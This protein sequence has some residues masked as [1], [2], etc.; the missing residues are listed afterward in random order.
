MIDITPTTTKLLK[1]R[2]IEIILA[3][4]EKH[5]AQF[6][7]AE[8]D[9]ILASHNEHTFADTVGYPQDSRGHNVNDRNY[10]DDKNA[11]ARVVEMAANLEPSILVTTSRTAS[12]TPIITEPGIVVSGNNRTMSLKLAASDHP[13]QYLEYKKFLAE[14]I[15]SFGFEQLIGT[16]LLLGS[17]IFVD[18]SSFHDS[19]SITFEK[20]ILVRIDYDFPDY[21]TFELA[22]YNKETKKAERPVDKA[23]KLS[24]ILSDNQGLRDS[25]ANI[26]GEFETLSDFYASRSEQKH[27]M[28]ILVEA[29]LIT[30]QEKPA[31]YSPESGFNPTGKDLVEL[32]LSSLV[33]QKETLQATEMEG[34]R[35]FRAT[36]VTSLPVLVKNDSLKHGNLVPAIN[37]AIE[38]AVKI[39]TSKL[40]FMDYMAQLDMFAAPPTRK[41]AILYC[42][43]ESGR[44]TFKKAIELYNQ[45]VLENEGTSLFE[46]I[47]LTPDEIFE[48]RIAY[49]IDKKDLEVVEKYLNKELPLVKESSKIDNNNPFPN[50]KIP[51]TV[52]H[53]T[54]KEFEKFDHGTKGSNT[55]GRNTF[56]GFFFSEKVQHTALFGERV[57]A[58]KINVMKPLDIRLNSIFKIEEQASD[59]YYILQG[60]RLSNKE[61]LERL[62]DEIGLG[63]IDDVR[64]A[65]N[66]QESHD[67]MVELGYDCIIS[68][69]GDGEVEYIVFEPEQ[70]HILAQDL[71]TVA[72]NTN[73]LI[74][75]NWYATY[76]EKILGEPYET[77]GRF[78]KVTKYRG[79][80]SSLDKIYTGI[81]LETSIRK[82]EQK[83]ASNIAAVVVEEREPEFPEKTVGEVTYFEE[84]PSDIKGQIE[85]MAMMSVKPEEV[86]EIA[87]QPEF[88]E[89]AEQHPTGIAE[90]AVIEQPLL[91]VEVELPVPAKPL[92]IDLVSLHPSELVTGSDY[93]TMADGEFGPAGTKV[94]LMGKGDGQGNELLIRK[95]MPDGKH[96]KG[97]A[98]IGLIGQKPQGYKPVTT[99]EQIIAQAKTE[100]ARKSVARIKAKQD[101][102]TFSMPVVEMQSFEEIYRLYNPEISQEELKVFVFYKEGIGQRLSDKWTRL[103]FGS[104]PMP[105]AT[106]VEW[107]ENGLLCYHQG[108]MLPSFL[109]YAENVWQR[110]LDLEQDRAIII[111]RYGQQVF[112][113]QSQKLEKLFLETVYKK[114]LLLNDSDEVQ[115]LR[116]TPISQFAKDFK[117]KSLADEKPFYIRMRGGE[118]ALLDTVIDPGYSEKRMYQGFDEMNLTEAFML[119]MAFNKNKLEYKRN[120]TY[121]DI[122][123]AYILDKSRPRNNSKM[124]D[125]EW[126]AQWSR[127]KENAQVEGDRLF[128]YFLANEITLNDKVRIETEWNIKFNAYVPIDYDKVPVAFSVAK[129]YRNEFVEVRPEK[130]EAVAIAILQGSQI[131]AFDVGFGKTWTLIMIFKALLEAGYCTR[132]FL[133]TPNQ[134]Y[135]QF[136]SEFKGLMP[137]V[138]VIDLYNLGKDYM[139]ELRGKDGKVSMLP[140]G[141]MALATY[142]GLERV[143]FNENT[144][145]YLLGQMYEILENVKPDKQMLPKQREQFQQKLET[146]LGTGLRNTIVNIEDLGIDFLSIDEAHNMKKIFT[147]VK[148]EGSLNFDQKGKI[149]LSREHTPY[150]IDSG[151][152]SMIGL[153]A[154][155][156]SQYIQ[157]NNNGRNVVLLTATPFTNSPLE[158][159]SMLALVAYQ[160][161]S[162]TS[163]QNLTVFFD[164]FIEISY[165]LVI[166]ATLQPVRKQVV[167]GFSNLPALQQIIFRYINFKNGDTK[168]KFGNPAVKVVRPN[169]WRLP[170][171]YKSV[172]GVTELLPENERISTIIPMTAT[173]ASLMSDIRLYV[174]GGI[175]YDELCRV[176]GKPKHSIEDQEE[177]QGEELEEISEQSLNDKEKRSVRMLRGISMARKLAL[178]PYL[179]E[180]SG[181]PE[182]PSPSQFVNESPKI[183]YAL[184]SIKQIKEFCKKE[185]VIM[186][187]QVIYMDLGKAFFPLIKRYLVEEVGF[188]SHEVAIV[189][190]GMPKTGKNSKEAIK[191]LFN[192]QIYNEASRAFE[193]VEDDERV[194]IVLGTSTIVEGMNLQRYSTHL[195]NLTVDWNPTDDQQLEG[196]IWRQ[197]NTYLNVAIILLLVE[198]SM[199]IFIFQ[200]LEEKSKRIN[201]IWDRDGQSSVFKFEEFNPEEAKY[202]M[203]SDPN[204]LAKLEV[205][206]T[207]ARLQDELAALT[208]EQRRIVE[209]RKN[210]TT[211]EDAKEMLVEEAAKHRKLYGNESVERLIKLILDVE[212]TQM[213][214]AELEK[215]VEERLPLQQ[216]YKYDS[217][218]RFYGYKRPS[219]LDTVNWANRQSKRDQ[220]NYLMPRNLQFKDLEKYQN[221]LALRSDGI[222]EEI[223][224]ITSEESLKVRA[225]AIAERRA[226]Q[227]IETKSVKARVAE[228]AKLNWIALERVVNVQSSNSEPKVESQKL[229]CPPKDASGKLRIDAEALSQLNVCIEALPQTK[230]MYLVEGTEDYTPSREKLHH[231]IIEDL[232]EGHQCVKREK[233]LAILTGG[234]PGAGKSTYLKRHAAWLTS[235]KVF[236]IDADEVRSMLPE[237]EGW[238][239]NATHLETKDI[240]NQLL[241]SIGK[242]CN[243]DL[244]YD[245]TMN[246]AKNY[247]PLIEK[248]QKLGYKVFVIYFQVPLDVSLER[249]LKR[250]QDTGRYVPTFVIHEAYQ[251]GIKTFE[252]IKQIVDGYMLIDGVSGVTIERGGEQMREDRNYTLP[253]NANDKPESEELEEIRGILK[254]YKE[255][256][257]EEHDEEIAGIAKIYEEMLEEVA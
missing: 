28:D 237:Y 46:N 151:M 70:I 164:Q 68:S 120:I 174:E 190:S 116:L 211:V 1:G 253:E 99:P 141:S 14:E 194:K 13:E 246:K 82:A 122:V 61:A 104:D 206:D 38:I 69:L 107:V 202:E 130:R 62:N 24:H 89:Q 166:T 147:R 78:G 168:D 131:V 257:E 209:I 115:A 181:L 112:D 52:Y 76:P 6:A 210:H 95:F 74:N 63:E 205:E 19:H 35:K 185:G 252:T 96:I 204:V 214:S 256:L 59:I 184:L 31:Y 32:L 177:I 139:D 243:F 36:I 16:N 220:D 34:V 187:G 158:V 117:V 175:E 135:R 54:N 127:T 22:K 132:G 25:V 239:A 124:S 125:S 222:K 23:I 226:E 51:Q 223:S 109:Y 195:Y 171:K 145:S 118:K 224:A 159:Y 242:P 229:E 163:I 128:A 150:Q 203:I 113:S 71:K 207:I 189:T 111:E 49:A 244:V 191:N 179:F 87:A 240:V 221:Q 241:D 212:F 238:N 48:K 129:N 180:C 247:I 43:L 186:P 119:W 91:S 40:S 218:L 12:G 41:A 97:V 58:A 121:L 44:N 255:M 105:V 42:L 155:M 45:S 136:M 134:V 167:T 183:Q 178:S 64:D 165:Q 39:H 248:L 110:K 30:E 188:K 232:M 152:P 225:Q 79:S 138:P 254:L 65:F 77:T 196:R 37:S 161:L 101:I 140:E 102:E 108:K 50:S 157:H 8:L 93:F 57:I 4:G 182:D 201:Q 27:L 55:E 230:F 21:S 67:M 7:I 200:K 215:P 86:L 126:I 84:L 90:T 249:T 142:E 26:V 73:M 9:E 213:D 156:L 162:S 2:N 5:K 198:N 20:P 60:S 154:F 18:G 3:N 192:G 217:N 199:D 153:K 133:A 173:Q 149:K 88:T 250:Y 235:D 11:Q 146:A 47:Q 123:N 197:G 17:P 80:L 148:G 176:S 172:N 81:D 234:L 100:I 208:S 10:K 106:P 75:D 29:S 228:L 83:N 227:K 144:Q 33:L 72:K 170:L 233:P 193:D 56:H 169:K 103:A 219:W 160:S 245:G 15:M 251:S 66:M 231:E 98:N 236:K 137:D 216:K 85:Q 94:M 114:R 92:E 53:G 143:G